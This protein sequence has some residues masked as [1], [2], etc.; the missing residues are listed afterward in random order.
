MRE[1]VIELTI[2]K[3]KVILDVDLDTAIGDIGSD[4]D[5]IA[6]QI[7]WY[8][9]V[10]AACQRAATLA[11]TNYRAWRAVTANDACAR[12]PGGKLAEHILKNMIEGDPKFIQHKE[13]IS[14]YEE[15]VTRV[16]K[17][18]LAL[19]IKADILRS[20][21]ATERAEWGATGMVSRVQDPVRDRVAPTQARDTAK[22]A[23][24]E[25][26]DAGIQNMTGFDEARAER[27]RRRPQPESPP[28]GNE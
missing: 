27:R 26:R 14:Y 28:K 6:S 22:A 7:A 10:L 25:E 21:A 19:E 24:R 9:R 13:T 15:L 16:A 18:L 4:M 2:N 17:A 20:R 3:E 23:E 5:A 12:T 1:N 11:D 8:G